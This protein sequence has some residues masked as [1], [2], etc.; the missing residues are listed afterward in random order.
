MRR[1]AFWGVALLLLSAFMFG[2]PASV[3]KP[4]YSIGWSPGAVVLVR[5][6]GGALLLLIP[7]L[8][9]LRGQWAN[10]RRNLK[11]IIVY[12]AVGVAGA[13]AFYFLAIQHMSIAVAILLEIA[14]APILV[15]LWLWL[16]H[17]QRPGLITAAGAL[18]SVVG[19]V[20]VLDIRG[21]A[22]S[23]VG[24]V[25]CLIAAA[26]VAAYFFI[27]ADTEMGINP[28][29]LTGLGMLVGA[30]AVGLANLTQLMPAQ[31]AVGSVTLAGHTVAWWVPVVLMV[32]FTV[33][34]FIFGII[35]VRMLGPTVG[36]FVNLSEIPFAAIAAWFILAEAL[37]GGQLIGGL[38]MLVGIVLV[39]IGDVRAAN[40]IVEPIQTGAIELPKH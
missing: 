13:Q 2:V 35:S 38:I 6:V 29:A 25:L 10:V 17:R 27:S 40:V 9:L 11:T 19:A 22:W 32:V 7:T 15:V 36:S 20:F 5:L 16:R 23:P 33:V 4:L 24:V 1:Q 26:C 3:A 30:V 37:T 39:K 31:F 12:G 21:A 18:I 14:G 8:V 28:I 34:G